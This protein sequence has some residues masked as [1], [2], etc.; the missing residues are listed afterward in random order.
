MYYSLSRYTFSEHQEMS[1]LKEKV[2]SYN[3]VYF[4]VVLSRAGADD[5][6]LSRSLALFL[7]GVGIISKRNKVQI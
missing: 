7:F 4:I 3:Y 5:P 6:I 1:A 2:Q